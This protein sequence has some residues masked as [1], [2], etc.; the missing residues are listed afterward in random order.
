MI[1]TL[2]AL[3]LFGLYAAV[4]AAFLS[5]VFSTLVEERNLIY[6]APLLFAATALFFERRRMH[7]FALAAAAGFA[8]YLI[9]TTP[10]QMQVHFYSDAPGLAILQGANRRLSFTPADARW[11]LLVLLVVALVLPLLIQHRLAWRDATFAI[12][13]I[14]V[15]VVAW[16]LT[17][18]ISAA[19]ASNDFSR[20]FL[21]RIP[22]PPDWVDQQ[23][24]GSPT[25][26]LGQRIVDP[27]NLWLTEFWN[28]SLKYTWSLDGTAPGPGETVTPNIMTNQG[29]LQQQ[30]GEVK[31]VLLDSDLLSVL[32]HTKAKIGPW[33][34]VQIDY[35]VRLTQATTGFYV[36]GWMGHRALY[37]HF[38]SPK[39]GRPGVV[40]VVVSRTGWGGTDVPGHVTIRVG[41]LRITPGDTGSNLALEAGDCDPDVDGALPPAEDVPRADAEAALR[42]RG[43]GHA[44]VRPAAARSAEPRPAR[45]GGDRQLQAGRRGSRSGAQVDRQAPVVEL[46]RKA[47]CELR[48][49]LGVGTEGP[50]RHDGAHIV[51]LD[52]VEDLLLGE[53][54]G[55]EAEEGGVDEL[56]RALAAREHVDDRLVG[57]DEVAGAREPADLTRCP[58]H[59]RG[60][61]GRVAVVAAPL[62]GEPRGEREPQHEPGGDRPAPAELGRSGAEGDSRRDGERHRE[63]HHVV[64]VQRVVPDQEERRGDRPGDERPQGDAQARP[65]RR[66]PHDEREQHEPAERRPEIEEVHDAVD[67]VAE[68]E[69]RARDAARPVVVVDR[70]TQIPCSPLR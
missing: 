28:R 56:A 59:V 60:L 58:D 26:Y 43:D 2:S 70:S 7:V 34:L 57:D 19:A 48:Q 39:Q 47:P 67:V 52:H 54:A 66:Q 51:A 36:D 30:R 23:T 63:Q 25:L 41:K 35:P 33:R 31:Y 10:Y 27:N 62:L 13:G 68:P 15:L 69:P 21:T 5:A 32:G 1:V 20:Q 50:G 42:S 44:D 49:E 46:P 37:A 12:A 24:G 64:V 16:N 29:Q 3:V 65:Q 22:D 17:G 11:L 4:K 18:E 53:Q 55:I 14:A 38:A 6:L 40:K 9:L 61:P 45:P 8:L